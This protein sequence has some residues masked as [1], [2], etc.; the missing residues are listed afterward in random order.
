[1]HILSTDESFLEYVQEVKLSSNISV[2]PTF[3]GPAHWCITDEEVKT[4]LTQSPL[5]G[6]QA[7]C[8]SEK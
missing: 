7:A 6:I 2:S 1:M 8:E 3:C 5:I 4:F